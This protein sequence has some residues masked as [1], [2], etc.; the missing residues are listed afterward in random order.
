MLIP[1]KKLIFSLFYNIS[2]FLILIIGI[3]NSSNKKK[4]Y[5]MSAE[6]VRMPISFIIG[7]SFISGS[8]AGSLLTFK[9]WD[10]KDL[11]DS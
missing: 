8:F 5:L 1:F 3:Q 9:Y 2:L 10:N 11:K 6:T 7:L 4:V